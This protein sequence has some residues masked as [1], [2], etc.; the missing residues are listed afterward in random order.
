LL[1]FINGFRTYQPA[2][3]TAV[4]LPRHRNTTGVLK[5]AQVIYALGGVSN[6]ELYA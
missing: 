6:R 1:T 2:V 5:V 3:E 4:C